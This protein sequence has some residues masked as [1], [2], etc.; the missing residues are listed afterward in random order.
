MSRELAPRATGV[1]ALEAVIA[2]GDLN[3]LSASQRLDLYQ[4]TC[5]SLGLNPLTRPLEYL[6]L[7]GKTV[8]YVRKEA[9]D[10][11]RKIHSITIQ[12]IERVIENDVLTVV[13]RASTPEGRCDEEI[14]SVSVAGLKGEALANAQ[15]K[16]LTKAKRRAT[17]SIC[18]LGFLDETETDAVAPP[19]P[20]L[21]PRPQ[22]SPAD[23][24]RELAIVAEQQGLGEHILS[25]DE[26]TPADQVR[27]A[28]SFLRKV[29]ASNA[30]A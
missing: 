5:E 16:A 12:I 13:A 10:Q 27:E 15:M 24:Y 2:A 28:Y 30:T 17:L 4:R 7:Q 20:V 23:H 8:I 1:D 6:K 18:G 11:L 29:I 26:D 14:G 9:C 22:K 21:T 19:V 25:I 3:N